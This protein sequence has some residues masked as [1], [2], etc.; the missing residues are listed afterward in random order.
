MGNHTA[1]YHLNKNGFVSDDEFDLVINANTNGEAV[2]INNPLPVVNVGSSNNIDLAAGNLEGYSHINKFGFT[3]TDINGAATVWDHSGTTAVYPYVAASTVTATGSNTNDDTKTIRVTGL[4]QNYLPLEETLIVGG[5]ASTSQFVRVFRAEMLSAI[6]TV[7][8]SITQ[9]STVVAKILAGNSQTLMAVYTVPAGKTA[10][11]LEFAG[12]I[13]KANAGV[14]FRLIARDFD[15]SDGTFTIKGLWGTQ[16]G[17]PVVYRYPVPLV[18]PEKSDI[19]V[20]VL[21]SATCGCGAIFD[22]V[23]VDNA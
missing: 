15:I 19:R 16:G 7:D 12:S 18:F 14:Q 20:D 13:D 21:T 17:N 22:I 5:A 10:Y 1:Q 9:S 6:N 2:T 11:L 3:G 4:D 23:L 8:V